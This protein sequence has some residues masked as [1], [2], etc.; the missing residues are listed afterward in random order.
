LH[1]IHEDASLGVSRRQKSGEDPVEEPLA[2]GK[3]VEPREP[4]VRRED[5]RIR[6]RR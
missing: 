1:G 6:V 3:R 2:I 5:R 4:R